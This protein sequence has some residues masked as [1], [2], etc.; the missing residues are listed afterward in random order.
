MFVSL[1][2]LFGFPASKAVHSP[3]NEIPLKRAPKAQRGADSVSTAR[4]RARAQAVLE[5]VKDAPANPAR[6]QVVKV[7]SGTS[8]AAEKPAP[9]KSISPLVEVVRGKKVKS[10][11]VNPSGKVGSPSKSS[12]STKLPAKVQ[13]KESVKT[14]IVKTAKP[15]VAVTKA[16]VTHSVAAGTMSKAAVSKPVAE[17]VGFDFGPVSARALRSTLVAFGP[18]DC[19]FHGAVG[20]LDGG[21]GQ[22]CAG[23]V[24]ASDHSAPG[25]CGQERPQT[26]QQL[27]NQIG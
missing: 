27:E 11:S 17:V 10:G 18:V 8:Q 16:K 15:E 19:A 5:K 25:F 26:G 24:T 1:L 2:Q 13:V 20:G 4:R 22:F 9:R 6:R 12:N 7:Q 14:S 21:Q 23:T 3:A